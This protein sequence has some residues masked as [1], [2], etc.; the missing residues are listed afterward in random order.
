MGLCRQIGTRKGCKMSDEQTARAI[1]KRTYGNV[2]NFM[3]PNLIEYGLIA[4]YM[5]YELSKGEGIGGGTI[6]GVTVLR[7]KYGKPTEKLRELS[8][9]FET[10]ALAKRHISKIIEQEKAANVQ[11]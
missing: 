4:P 8:E 1:F 5:A 9:C 11:V 7:S 3:T 6:Y 10:I 2:G